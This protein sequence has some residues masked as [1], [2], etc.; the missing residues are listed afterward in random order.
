MTQSMVEPMTPRSM[1]P[2]SRVPSAPGSLRDGSVITPPASPGATRRA[3]DDDVFLRL[4]GAYQD[5]SPQGVVKEMVQKRISGGGNTGATSAWIQ[6]THVAE[7]HAGAALALSA[8][9][10][11]LYSGG[12][13]ESPGALKSPL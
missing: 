8:T 11:L 2:L 7:G 1:I 13:G 6:C 12:V 10:H 3:R 9:E 5:N 4:A